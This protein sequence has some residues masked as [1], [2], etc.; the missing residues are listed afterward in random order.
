MISPI[1]DKFQQHPSD[2]GETY[3]E[4]FYHALGLLYA[5]SLQPA[6]VLFMLSCRF[7]LLAREVR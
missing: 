5:F 1:L 6:L 2:V 4:H 3:W 7:F